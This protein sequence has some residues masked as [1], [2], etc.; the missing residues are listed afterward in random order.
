MSAALLKFQKNYIWNGIMKKQIH[1]VG[2]FGFSWQNVFG[3]GRLVLPRWSSPMPPESSPLPLEMLIGKMVETRR[4]AAGTSGPEEPCGGEFPGSLT[5][6]LSRTRRCTVSELE[7]P[8]G[9]EGKS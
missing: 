6:Y 7:Q 3:W 9:T 2:A 8:K 4:Q 1:T 5:A